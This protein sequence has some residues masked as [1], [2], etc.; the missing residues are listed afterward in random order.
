MY[1]HLPSS[2]QF[3]E[4]INGLRAWAVMGVLLFHFSFIGLPGG[5]TGVDIFFVISGYLMTAIVLKG[6]ESGKF[7][8]TQF[9]LSRIRRILPA[10][11][12]LITILVFL[13]W[14]W[15]PPIDYKELGN[16]ATAALGFFS[17][18]HFWQS[19]GYFDSAAQEKWLL[20][21]W[22]LAVEAQFYILY[23]VYLGVIWWLFRSLKV[24]A[25]AVGLAL[26]FSYGMN[27]WLSPVD[28]SFSFYLLP[29]RVWEFAAGGLTFLAIRLWSFSTRF[30]FWS[31]WL[32]WSMLL[33]SFTVIEESFVWPGTWAL[34]PVLGTSLIILGQNT[35]GVMTNH[36]LAQ[37]LGDRSYSLYLWHWPLVVGL[38]FT[39]LE[40]NAFWVFAMLGLSLLLG[41]LSYLFIEVPTRQFLAQRS[42]I[43]EVSAIAMFAGALVTSIITIKLG[44]FGNRLP[45]EVV[46]VDSEKTNRYPR[47]EQCLR[48]S[49]KTDT[50]VNCVFEKQTFDLNRGII[51]I[52]DSHN[53]A[54]FTALG[55]TA[56]RYDYTAMH[57]AKNTCPFILGTEYYPKQEQ[58][59]C[60]DFN[61]K[62][63]ERLENYK[64]VPV[65]LIARWSVAIKG[66]NEYPDDPPNS[67]F[68]YNGKWVDYHD[69]QYLEAFEHNLVE[70]ACRL[71]KNHDVYMV[72]PLPEMGTNVPKTLSRN[73]M[74]QGYSKD[75]KITLKEY[76]ERHKEVWLAQNKAAKKCG[77]TLLNPLPYLCDN[78]YC[79]GSIEGKPLYYDDDHLSE[80]GNKR[81][82]PM[83]DKM[84]RQ[85]TN[86]LG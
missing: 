30:K 6:L 69:N 5:F 33:V 72:R 26:S 14:F 62:V 52:G 82:K 49:D 65:V 66:K 47:L 34:L 64:K 43:K 16:Q 79:Y 10:L 63:V 70:T 41:H 74:L 13:G 71:S 86:T 3:R 24:I 19:A 67:A 32:G 12:V 4:D 78:K 53:Q 80:H 61:K 85:I 37:W 31:Y 57:W 1:T 51:S 17:N 55:E 21:T 48:V 7:S 27:I 73:F 59:S 45:A 29:T 58:A 2:V 39:G 23:P 35:E 56:D 20:H 40:A 84:F 83:F 25:I 11:M 28:P 75:I 46:R 9:Y 60:N 18:I 76:F 68:F 54:L 15:L 44:D 38:F 42:F 22:S 8:F 77:I 36:R 50:P 81:L